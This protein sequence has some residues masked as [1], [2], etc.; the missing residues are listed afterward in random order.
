VEPAA[1]RSDSPAPR[2]V[3]TLRETPAGPQDHKPIGRQPAE[4]A[5]L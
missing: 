5:E 3:I 1:A 4:H 2:H